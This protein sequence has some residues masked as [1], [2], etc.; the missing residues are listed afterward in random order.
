MEI[1]SLTPSLRLGQAL[2]A[3][4]RLA[5]QPGRA[6]RAMDFARA[7]I[8][9]AVE[10]DQHAP[11]E[12][13]E[14]VQSAVALREVIDRLP[15][16]RMQQCR[17]GGIEHVAN[18]VVAGDLGHAEQAGAVRAPEACLELALMRQKRRT[19]HEEHR[20]R[21][22]TDVG[23]IVR[24]VLSPPLVRKLIQTTAQ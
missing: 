19:L 5:Y 7:M 11:A 24:G 21:R 8:L 14:T 16:R 3:L 6:V 9:G 15:E 4:V 2:G 12:P 1:F 18:V 13:T 10:R 20:K 17:V 23:N 22:H